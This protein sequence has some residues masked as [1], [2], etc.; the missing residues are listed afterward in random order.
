MLQEWIGQQ[1]VVDMRS[2]F[3][4]LGTLRGLDELYLELVNADVHDL[5]DTDSTR[6]FYVAASRATGIKRNRKRVLLVRA[7]VVAVSLLEDVVDE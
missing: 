5:R 3:V 2:S 6:E 1:V 4:C 7:D